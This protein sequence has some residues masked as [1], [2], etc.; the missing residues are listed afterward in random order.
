M[1]KEGKMNI[2]KEFAFHVCVYKRIE[3]KVPKKSVTHTHTTTSAAATSALNFHTFND[4]NDNDDGFSNLHIVEILQAG[5]DNNP[6]SSS[7]S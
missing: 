3:L 5:N 1:K 6:L 7:S 2:G 4:D